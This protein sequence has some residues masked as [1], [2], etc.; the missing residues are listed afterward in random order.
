MVVKK[1]YCKPK[2]KKIK[3]FTDEAVL[4]PCKV[5]D[6]DPTGKAIANKWCGN[7]SCKIEL[8]S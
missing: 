6:G 3:L 7:N 8:G 4:Q 2:I 5:F 1:K